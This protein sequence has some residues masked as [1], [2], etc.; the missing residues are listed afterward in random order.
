MEIRGYKCFN[1]DLTNRYGK[2]IEVGSVYS[3]NGEVKFGNDGHGFHFC[4]NI[5][6]T[7]RYFDAMNDDVCICLVKGYGKIDT[8]D[9]EYYGYYDMY[10]SEHIEIL[11]LLSRK[12][13]I[14]I[15]LNLYPERAVRFVSGIKLSDDEIEMFK[16]KFKN[17]DCVI[18]AINYY[19][20]SDKDAYSK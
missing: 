1:K 10:A 17:N 15:G 20:L 3:T 11:K 18:R 19:Q 2:K 4:K 16:E 12:E 5:E 7:F 8:Y 14:D 13:I 6:D 9:D